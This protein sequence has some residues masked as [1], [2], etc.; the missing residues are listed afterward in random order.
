VLGNH[1]HGLPPIAG[2]ADDG[3][4]IDAIEQLAQA[5]PEEI[6]IVGYD[7]AQHV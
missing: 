3:H 5:L 2:L 7:D 6:M 4:V 1:H